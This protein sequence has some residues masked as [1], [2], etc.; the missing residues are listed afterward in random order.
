VGLLLL[1][2]TA[3]DG[4]DLRSGTVPV[5]DL[6]APLLRLPGVEQSTVDTRRDVDQLLGHRVL[7]RSSAAVSGESALRGARASAELAGVTYALAD[8]RTDAP[9]DPVLQGT[10]RISVALGPL[11]AVWSR[12]PLQVLARLHALA[13]YGLVPAD[14]L[15]RPRA[16]HD[17][18]RLAALAELA[19]APT[20]APAV[21]VAAVVHG[22]LLAME[23]FGAADGVIARAAQ[24][25][26]LVDR[27]LD[28]KAV[29]VPEVGH[30]ELASDYAAAAAGYASGEPA[31]VAQWL[32]HC[33]AAV[34]LGAREGTAVCQAVLR[35]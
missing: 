35:S 27:G 25:L 21:V 3:G 33:C 24:R 14:R 31:G 12:A 30:V 18:A 4:H 29:S 26:V 15:G 10:L 13:A 2:R 8:L 20:A 16:G 1:G 32:L 23:P 7:R 17:S 34:S 6:L 9:D 19:L 11:L 5:V 28:P 22:E